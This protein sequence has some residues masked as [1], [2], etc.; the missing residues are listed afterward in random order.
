LGSEETFAQ[1]SRVIKRD[2]FYVHNLSCYSERQHNKFKTGSFHCESDRFDPRRKT[3]FRA[4]STEGDADVTLWLFPY[5]NPNYG[6]T[7]LKLINAFKTVTAVQ[8]WPFSDSE[9]IVASVPEQKEDQ[10]KK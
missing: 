6:N 2:E 4:S 9:F 8:F 3:I 5:A 1:L 7:K 10:L